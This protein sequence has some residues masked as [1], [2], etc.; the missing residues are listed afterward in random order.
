M[1]IGWVP[2]IG[3]GRAAM[4][5]GLAGVVASTGGGESQPHPEAD[6]REEVHLVVP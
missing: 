3:S 4:P 5:S 6:A 1:L 2:H